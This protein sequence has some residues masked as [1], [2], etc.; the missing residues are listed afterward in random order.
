MT[1][2]EAAEAVL[3]KAGKPL[4]FKKITQI[5]IDENLLSHVGKTPEVTMSTRLATLTRR[6]DPSQNI[7][8]VRPGVFGLREWGSIDAAAVEET[9]T[10]E[11]TEV[12]APAEAAPAADAAAPSVVNGADVTAE[13]ASEELGADEVVTH[14][15]AAP[16]APEVD[17]SP[18]TPEEIERMARM[19]AAVEGLSEEDDDEEPLLG[20]SAE[21]QDGNKRRRRRRRRGRAGER[22]DGTPGAEGEEGAAVAA[23]GEAPVEGAA[24]EG[25]APREAGDRPEPA[26]SERGEERGRGRRG[27]R[28]DRGPREARGGEGRR[29]EGRRDERSDVRV[30]APEGREEEIGRDTADAVVAILARRDDR[31]PVALRTL[32]EEGLRTGKLAGDPALLQ[33][34][35][36][37]A[38][39]V[40]GARRG[41]RG[42]RARLRLAGGRVG[43][44]DWT[45]PPD[46]VRAEAEALAALERL[47]DASRR[48][49]VRRINELPQA[50]FVEAAA[51]LLER[52][53]ISSLRSTRRPGVSQ[54]EAH[55][56]GI[57]RRGPE[58]IP[59][60][61]VLR[62]GGEVGRERVIELRGS[63]HHYNNAR[64]GWLLTTGQVL[65]GARDE[66]SQ[67]GAAPV[68]LVDG[69]GLGRLLDEH[70]VLVSH[71]TVTLPYLDI[72]LF[73]QLRGS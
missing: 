10:A 18:R 41:L 29:D 34:T 73:D 19:A 15:P 66:A 22:A 12:A 44:L 50:S 47:R 49:V 46:L 52:M 57:A 59:V 5:S 24:V 4:H 9:D 14:T 58:E 35:V 11:T 38:I 62:R 26:R 72:D 23:E 71:A 68:T 1:F 67:D 55:L 65:S 2:T 28:G 21:K 42:E 40:D 20:G 31:Q 3:R 70:K 60:A 39:R 16:A 6:D 53:G 51:L 43:L 17:E 45:L 7:V 8:R 54:V 32:I 30:E 61:I 64:A 25:E 27:D 36:S 63:L 13:H 69:V 37:A 33:S 56:C 48:Y